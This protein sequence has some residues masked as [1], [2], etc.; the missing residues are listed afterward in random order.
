MR[1]GYFDDA[2]RQY[3]IERPDTPMSWVNYLG[4]DQYCAI[5]SNNAAGYAFHRSPKTGRLLRFRFN[6]VPMDRPGRYFYLRD[7]EDGDFWSVSWQPV[8]KPLDQAHY[9]CAHGPGVT[10]F[11]SRYRDI[12]ATLRAFVP[13]GESA[14]VWELTVKNTGDRPRKLGVFGYAEWCFWHMNQDAFNFQYILY[15]CRMGAEDGIVDYTVRLWPFEEPKG[16]FAT[17]LPVTSFDTDREVF[18][19]GYRHEGQPLAVERGR[20]FDSVAVGG[21]PCG[22]LHSDIELQPG[23]SRTAVYIIGVGDAQTKGR[24]LRTRLSAPGEIDRELGRL[25][26][27]WDQRLNKLRLE[28]PSAEVN[29]MGNVWNQIQCH[30]TFSWSR[31]ASFNEA[32]GRDGLGYRDTCQDTL[33]VVHA[34]PEQVKAKLVDLLKAQYSF[35]A[36]MHHVQP[37]EWKQGPHNIAAQH[38]SDDHLWLLLA[39]PAYI[40]ETGDFAWLDEQ[41]AFADEGRASVYDHLKRAIDFSWSKRGPHGLCLGLAAD[42]NDCLNL[43]GQG[44]TMFSSF[45]LLRGLRELIELAERTVHLTP[46]RKHDIEQYG[47][48]RDK[49]LA[50]ISEHAWDGEW[51][52]RGYLDS[53]RKLG[54]HESEGSTIFLNAQSWAVLADAAPRDLLVRA[55]DSVHRHLATPHGIVLNSPSY[56]EHDAEVGAI[57]TFPPG[58]KE[59]GGIFCHA[60]TWAVIA[61]TEL[62]RGDQAFELYRSFLPSAKNDTADLH[63]MEPYVYAQFVT[64]QDHPYRFGRARNSWL[65]GTATWAFVALTQHILGVRA[66]Y[67]GLVVDPVLPKA[68]EGFTMT[69]EFRGARYEITVRQGG[70]VSG[71]SDGAT[72]QLFVDGELVR[73]NQ[74]AIAPAGTT[75]KVE[76]VLG[77]SEASLTEASSAE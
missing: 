35:G 27:Y 15:T 55:M 75:V 22:A 58:L 40:R 32:G 42:W 41:V 48:L 62:G 52:L 72:R 60:N 59:N 29:S 26:A 76:L 73:G 74:V 68:W 1:Y 9:V 36:A 7:A 71:V 64:G 16:Y 57:T 17:S 47:R 38:F 39:I 45:L 43:R 8:A 61:E 6:S 67:D 46:A 10:R 69:R 3:V 44:E 11:E 37:L 18:L 12:E 24:E 33:G 23:E 50:V 63:S 49:L 70:A 5:V 66:A 34:I 51:F 53:G 2:T 77:S 14:E 4:T 21:T 19:G 56:T 30:T 13:V 20:C 31:S 54:S 25:S 65:T 28:T